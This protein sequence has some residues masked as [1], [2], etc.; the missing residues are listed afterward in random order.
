MPLDC[1]VCGAAVSDD[2][3]R[4]SSELQHCAAHTGTR[5][6]SLRRGDRGA[7]AAHGP[8]ARRLHPVLRRQREIPEELALLFRSI[9]EHLGLALENARLLRENMRM[10]LMNERELIAN[11]VHDSLA[12]TLAYMNIRL[13]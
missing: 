13:A 2:A 11:E 9:S 6:F 7:A 10:T 3:V 8:R 4:Q 12:Q 1:G 5:V